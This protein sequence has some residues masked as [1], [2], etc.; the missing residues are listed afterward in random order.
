MAEATTGNS[1]PHKPSRDAGPLLR[2]TSTVRGVF[3]VSANLAG[4]LAINAFLHYLNTRLWLDFSLAGYRK[5]LTTPLSETFLHPLSIFSHPWMMVL[6]GLLLSAVIFVPIMV[7]VLYR[8]WVSGLFVLTVAVIGHWPLLAAF[9]AAG[10][11]LAG[12]TRLRRSLPFLA[13]L[14]GLAPVG[15]YLGLF[16]RSTDIVLT[17]LQWFVLYMLLVLVVVAAMLAGVGVLALARAT[18]FRPGVIWPA[19]LVFLVPPVWLFYQKIGPAE[20]D[21]ALTAGRLQRSDALFASETLADFARSHP[22]V[23]GAKAG[24]A[25][26]QAARKAL[27]RRREALLAECDAFLRR[28]PRSSRG[29]AVLWIR[30]VAVDVEIDLQA[31]G[32][33]FVRYGSTS[34]SKSSIGRWGEIAYP[35]RYALAPQAMVAHQRLGIDALRDGRMQ[36]AFEDLHIAGSSLMTH[37]GNKGAEASASLWARVFIP[38]ESLPGEEYYREVL[39]ET[40]GL[41]WLMN[42]NRVVEGNKA[43]ADAFSDYMRLWPFGNLTSA[44]LAELSASSKGTELEDNFQLLM[45]MAEKDELERARKLTPVTAGLKDAAIIANYELGHLAMRHGSDPAW[46]AKGLKAAEHYFNIVRAARRNPYKA[47]AEKQLARLAAREAPGP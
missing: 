46:A 32:Q 34:P 42:E 10:C 6:I 8:L 40:E 3:F 14:V 47:L 33:G 12:R 39:A 9:L 27:S 44:A 43:N 22:E 1:D 20:L 41:L 18:R 25:M 26:L 29:A 2:R 19:L 15:A 7:A 17:P 16:S 4:F 38:A 13:L 35:Q 45:A 21:Y 24:D 37:L 23:S 5:A 28:H 36:K 11:I 31:F 30:A